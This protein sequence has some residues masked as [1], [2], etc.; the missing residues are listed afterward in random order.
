MALITS[1][2]APCC[3]P[4]VQGAPPAVV[5]NVMGGFRSVGWDVKTN[6]PV[7]G[8]NEPLEILPSSCPL[9]RKIVLPF[10]R[11]PSSLFE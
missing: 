6:G 8:G 1:D 10:S 5:N 3:R 9:S 2:C 7:N 4:L 11:R